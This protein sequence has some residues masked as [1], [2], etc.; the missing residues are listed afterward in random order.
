MIT[1]I[2]FLSMFNN[3]KRLGFLPEVRK[4]LTVQKFYAKL[5][6]WIVTIYYGYY[7]GSTILQN[8]REFVL[9]FWLKTLHE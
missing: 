4:S 7:P 2:R 1:N 5:V 8:C 6:N 9:E 3:I